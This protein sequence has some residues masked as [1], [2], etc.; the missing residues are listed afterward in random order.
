MS[1]WVRLV[2][3][4]PW[5]N[6]IR[7]NIYILN[8]VLRIYKTDLDLIIFCQKPVNE[9]KTFYLKFCAAQAHTET[10]QTAEKLILVQNICLEPY[11]CEETYHLTGTAGN[12]AGQRL[13]VLWNVLTGNIFHF[14]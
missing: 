4:P 5:I 7:E 13:L 2:Q 10:S 14:R 3:I 11:V 9:L 6:K 12:L 1:P 8:N